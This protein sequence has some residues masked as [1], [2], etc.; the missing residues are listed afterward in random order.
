MIRPWLGRLAMLCA[1]SAQAECVAR[2]QVPSL[3]LISPWLA[4]ELAHGGQL[5]ERIDV[6][7]SDAQGC[8]PLAIGVDID[9]PATGSARAS[10]RAAPNGA[11]IGSMP[12]AAQ[13][14]L[15]LTVGVDG[16]VAIDPVIEWSAQG[17]AL[18]AGREELRVRWRLYPAEALLPQALVE[19]ETL[20]VAEVPAVLDV[21]LIAA[22]ARLPLA[23]ASAMLDFGEVS[24]AA[25]R[26]VDIEVRGNAQVQLSVSRQWGELRLRDRPDYTIPYTLL[27][28]GRPLTDA[29][30][31]Q[32]LDA[33]SGLSRAHLSVRL[34]EVERRAA[35]VYEDTLT[36]VVAPE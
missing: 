1:G 6:R 24:S 12:G 16:A 11:E 33:S 18:P 17:Q 20:V 36:V 9:V 19:L 5:Q 25:E 35:G 22:G 23:G 30:L 21:E 29:G 8:G 10:M 4:L 13:P 32:A 31:P 7:V 15:A 3:Q 34:G 2:L 14:L 27:L 26:G 28:D